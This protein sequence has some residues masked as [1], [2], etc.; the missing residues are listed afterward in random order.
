MK[1]K[2]L[3]LVLIFVIVA[4]MCSTLVVAY[5]AGND[6]NGG[7]ADMSSSAD[8]TVKTEYEGYTADLGNLPITFVYGDKYYKGFSADHFGVVSR[9]SVEERHGVITTTKLKMYEDDRLMVTVETAFYEDYNAYDYTVYFE[10]CGTDNSAVLKYVNAMDID[11]DGSN[12]VL[13]GILG[14]HDNQYAPYERDLAEEDV[15]FTSIAGRAT[16]TYFPY[17]NLETDKGGAML[18]I[19]W[20]GTW[21]ADFRYDQESG[22]TNFV[23]TGTVGME[24]YLKP[25]E[26]VRTPLMAVV[27]YFERD[28]D[29]ATNAWRAWMVDCNIPRESAESEE[30]VQPFNLVC[31]HL[32]SGRP[33]SDG[34]I[35][36]GYDSWQRSMDAFYDHGLTATFRW[37]DAGWYETPYGGTETTDWWG[38]VGTWQIDTVKWPGDSFRES[39][40]YAHEKGTKTMVWFEPERV[41]HLDGMVNYGYDREWVLSDHGN[42]NCYLNNLGNADALEWTTNRILTFM[43]THD[44]DY[45]RE[46][47]NMDPGIFWSIG[48]GYEGEN[49][50]G[51]TENL[52]MQGHYTLWDNIIEWCCD[53]GKCPYVDS[54]ASGG[55]R[56]D[57]ES[58]RRGVPILRSDSDRTTIPLRLAMS[59]TFNKW[60][61]FNGASSNETGGAQIATGITDVYTMRASYLPIYFYNAQWYHA[62]D[63][64]N[65]DELK[66]GLNEWSDINKYLLKDY[67][68][69]TPYRGTTNDKDWTSWMYVDKDTDSAVLQAFRPASSTESTFKVECRGLNPDTYYS[70]RD[71][72]G[73]NSIAR[74]KGKALMN[75]LNLYAADARTAIVLYI[76]PIE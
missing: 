61:P 37:F 11:F 10:N 25:G 8:S 43:E 39:V 12:A 18:A 71:L 45:Y 69:L 63:T 26:T 44:V 32:D 76:D 52:Y 28:E 15:N 59:S 75:G 27:R 55:G 65:W 41:T 14:D 72:D 62:Q 35:S 7:N 50:T 34:S 64:L 68:V 33:N 5:A 49:R 66:Q 20:G 31:Y 17:F 42:N 47:F 16:H 13:K 3:C 73:V 53:N 9:T 56:N 48:D 67:Y 36:E 40:E 21:Q 23:G 6:S 2:L 38:T 60:I 24:T 30:S 70:V 58:M 1:K 4:A 46:D 74:V 29:I 22:R 19:G 54:C 57:L 51:I